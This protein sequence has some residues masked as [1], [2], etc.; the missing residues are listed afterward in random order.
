MTLYRIAVVGPSGV[1]MSAI[2]VRFTGNF[3]EKYN[4]T[5]EGYRKVVEV[6]GIDCMLDIMDTAEQQDYRALRDQYMKSADG[7][8]LVY[9]IT[10][11]ISFETASKLRQ[12]ILKNKEDYPDTPIMLVGNNLDMESDRAVQTADG[13]TLATKFGLGF[14]ECSAK[15]NVNVNE[16]FFEL[17][18]MINKWREKHNHGQTKKQTVKSGKGKICMLI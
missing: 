15:T 6:D 18:R 2:T 16:I 5:I 17:V 9:S 14:I 12:D 13:K 4:P 11:M 10:S 3:V 1:G 7:F 8:V